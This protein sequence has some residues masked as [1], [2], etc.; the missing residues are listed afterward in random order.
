MYLRELHLQ[1]IKCFPDLTLT[2]PAANDTGSWCVLLGENGTGKSTLLQAIALMLVNEV[3][4]NRLLGNPEPW[5]R[6]D[7]TSGKCRALLESPLGPPQYRVEVQFSAEAPT[8]AGGAEPSVA[9]ITKSLP[10]QFR[11]AWHNSWPHVFAGYGPFRRME[12]RVQWEGSGQ[13]WRQSDSFITLFQDG[14]G[15]QGLD[16][17]LLRMDYLSKDQGVESAQRQSAAD[18]LNQIVEIVNGVLPSEG[19]F[20]LEEV[21]ATGVFFRGH[22]G[23]HVLLSQMSDGYRAMFAL[24]VDLIRT[25]QRQCRPEP[26]ER[27][28]HREPDGRVWLDVR[29]IV[30]IDEVDIHLHPRWQQEVAEYLQRI[31]PKIQFIVASHSPF[32]AQDATDGGL[33]VLQRTPGSPHVTADTTLPSMHGFPAEDILLSPAFR[34]ETTRGDTETVERLAE[35]SRLTA[36]RKRGTLTAEQEARLAELSRELQ[37]VL[38]LEEA[39][40]KQVW[41][42]LRR[43]NAP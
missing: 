7:A 35:H 43:R 26:L 31:F 4:A 29:G 8:D 1:D 22:G 6:T 37:S 23:E 3:G 9:F 16:D 10:E 5:V 24:V 21:N 40:A 2:F 28:I 19:P 42:Q 17:W 14:V 11:L 36:L 25:M 33:I 27:F 41:D 30:L 15:L 12:T 38:R 20:H 39:H 32:I 18:C 34:L 13:R